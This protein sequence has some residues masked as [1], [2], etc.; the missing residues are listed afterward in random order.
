L[1]THFTVFFEKYRFRGI[2]H[3]VPAVYEIGNFASLAHSEHSK[4]HAISFSC[5]ELALLTGGKLKQGN[6]ACHQA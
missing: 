4:T 5:N 1:S 2:A 3:N 6:M